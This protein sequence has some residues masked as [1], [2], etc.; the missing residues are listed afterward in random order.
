MPLTLNVLVNGGPAMLL[1]V[2]TALT[3]RPFHLELAQIVHAIRYW[4]L[5][6]PAGAT[7]TPRKPA[8]SIIF[9]TNPDAFASSINSLT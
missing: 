4:G 9:F 7:W 5:G 1:D 6:F 3:A 2:G 8:S